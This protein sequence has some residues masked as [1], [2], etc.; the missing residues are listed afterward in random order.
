[1]LH[2]KKVSLCIKGFRIDKNQPN[3]KNFGIFLEI[4]LLFIKMMREL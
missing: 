2:S 3:I 1:M 4:Y